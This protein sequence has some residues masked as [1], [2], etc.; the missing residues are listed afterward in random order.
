ML[1]V[2]RA[3]LSNVAP[4]ELAGFSRPCAGSSWGSI[5]GSHDVVRK[6]HIAVRFGPKAN[7]PGYGFRQCVLQIALTIEVPFN[8]VTG[9]ADLQ[10]MPLLAGGRR[11]SHP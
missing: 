8:L 6:M 1:L 10:V 9:D 2:S 4:R 7:S 5:G 11:I 3:G